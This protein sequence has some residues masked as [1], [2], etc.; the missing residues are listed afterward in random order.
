MTSP[1]SAAGGRPARRRDLQK[2]QTRRDLALAAFNLARA[3][4]LANV[5]ISQIATAVGVSPRTF[6]NYFPSKEAAV[7]WPVT[8]Q[9]RWLADSLTNRPP[10]EPLA[11]ALVAAIAA[12]YRR[13]K[14]D[15]LPPGW[16][17]QFRALVAA[18]P[19]LHGEYLKATTATEAALA[20]AIGR[21]AGFPPGQLESHVLAAVTVAAER[22]AV[23]HWSRAPSPRGPLV[24]VVR[25]AVHLAVRGMTAAPGHTLA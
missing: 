1:L 2:E 7:I 25:T 5:R 19:T 17:G 13:T 6:N 23:Q 3:H 24:A 15:T 18:E 10:A 11:D 14:M 16:L 12:Q 20:D 9:A 8:L 22:T 4:G 21:R